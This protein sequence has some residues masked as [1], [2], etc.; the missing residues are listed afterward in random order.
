MPNAKINRP[1]RE[2]MDKMVSDLVQELDY[3][4]WKSLFDEDCMEDPEAAADTRKTL[5]AIVRRNLG[6]NKAP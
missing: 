5:R 4:H 1:T 3:D 2:Q 6:I